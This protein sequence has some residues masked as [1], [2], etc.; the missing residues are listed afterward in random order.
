[1]AGTYLREVRRLRRG[2]SPSTL[3]SPHHVA[4]VPPNANP[5]HTAPPPDGP[6]VHPC[7]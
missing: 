6:E 3:T 7:R 5:P 1:M 4:P 2:P